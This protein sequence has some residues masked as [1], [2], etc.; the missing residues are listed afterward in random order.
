MLDR[1]WEVI[2]Y[3]LA[4]NTEAFRIA[5]GLPQGEQIALFIVLLAGLSLGIGQSVILFF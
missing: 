4:L 2:G 1:F 5:A 3:V